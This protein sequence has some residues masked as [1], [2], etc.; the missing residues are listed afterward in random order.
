MIRQPPWS[1]RTD[2]LFPYT[3]LFRSHHGPPVSWP[4]SEPQLAM[5][6]QAVRHRTRTG[7]DP[8]GLPADVGVERGTEQDL[9]PPRSLSPEKIR[10]QCALSPK[11]I[12][13]Q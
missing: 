11:E 3:P 4:E 5:A 7:S 13:R 2:T 9:S 12:G 6:A 1:T 8:G 10:V